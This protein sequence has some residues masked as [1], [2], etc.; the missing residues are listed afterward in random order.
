MNNLPSSVLEQNLTTNPSPL[1]QQLEML[2]PMQMSTIWRS[3]LQEPFK[4]RPFV[5]SSAIS[6]CQDKRWQHSLPK[7][8]AQRFTSLI[9]KATAIFLLFP[10]RVI[11]IALKMINITN[12]AGSPMMTTEDGLAL[13]KTY[14]LPIGRS[15][16][17]FCWLSWEKGFCTGIGSHTTKPPH[18][19]KPPHSTASQ[20]S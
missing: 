3:I 17:P 6:S 4:S 9:S 13:K 15:M 16:A 8:R 1:L 10:Q 19:T 18:L 7:L 20:S 2:S 14:V 12:E 5:P 11:S